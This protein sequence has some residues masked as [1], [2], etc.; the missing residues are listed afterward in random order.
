MNVSRKLVLHFPK[1]MVDHPIICYL[2]R[3]YNLIF[4]VLRAQV[5]PQQEGLLIIELTGSEEDYE[6]GVDYLKGLGVTLQFLSQDIRHLD[7]RCTDCG[8]CTGVCPTGALSLDRPSM[9]LIF[10]DGKC[11]ACEAC[12][13]ACPTR[14]MVAEY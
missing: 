9:R 6:R 14:A 10:D 2:V 13:R 12:L 11:V 3:D 5:N 4:N 1:Q 7:D 8:A